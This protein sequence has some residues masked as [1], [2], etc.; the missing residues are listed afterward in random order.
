VA[1]RRKGGAIGDDG[2]PVG[3]PAPGAT[4]VTVAL[5]VTGAPNT[6]GSGEVVTVVVV[7]TWL[8]VWVVL[9]VE[10]RKPS[11]PL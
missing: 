5:S 7:I 11:S 3:V 1:A 6:E 10:G 4:G 2:V 8:T 9:P